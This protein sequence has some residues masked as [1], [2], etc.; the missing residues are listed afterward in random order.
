MDEYIDIGRI[1]RPRGLRGDVWIET[2]SDE[3]ARLFSGVQLYLRQKGELLPLKVVD[4]MLSGRRLSLRFA[5]VADRTAAEELRGSWLAMH[6]S[7]LP[8]LAEKENFVADLIGLEVR[9]EDGRFVGRVTDLLE[10]PASYV[11][12]IQRESYEALIPSLELFV[13]EVH[14]EDGY[15]V[16]RPL[17]GMLPTG[18]VSDDH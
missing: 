2:L 5:E 9:L 16:I 6:R 14:V 3:P 17:E 13:P 7:D 10:M 1:T 8:P 4:G 11:Y 12:V 15:L 18:M